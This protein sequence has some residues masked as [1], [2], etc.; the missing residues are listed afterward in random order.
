[1]T[2]TIV[3][4]PDATT[5][6]VYPKPIAADDAALSDSELAYA[7]INTTISNGDTI[8]RLNLDASAKTNLF[9]AEEAI[10]VIGGEIPAPLFSEFAGFK[11]VSDTLEN[12]LTMYL[13]YDGNIEDMSFRFRLFVWYGITVSCPNACG[14]GVTYT[15]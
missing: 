7:N 4:K 8:A 10:E 13:V 1:M 15:A 12:G 5:I 3:G 2:F 14:V 9:F 6:Q 11:V